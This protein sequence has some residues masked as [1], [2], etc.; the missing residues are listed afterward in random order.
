[1]GFKEYLESMLGKSRTRDLLSHG[2][3]GDVIIISGEHGSGRSTL[4]TVLRKNGFQV[5]EEE[6]DV[7]H[8]KLTKKLEK[9]I[10][11]YADTISLRRGTS[12]KC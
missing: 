6:I 5:F 4:A 12:E 3:C 10:P 8:V 1:M 7:H 9:M 11:N 2:R